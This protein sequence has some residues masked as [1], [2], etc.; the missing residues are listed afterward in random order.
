MREAMPFPSRVAERITGRISEFT[1]KPD[2]TFTDTLEGTQF[3]VG[4]ADAR[5]R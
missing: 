1:V 3:Q 5:D 4:Y 2:I